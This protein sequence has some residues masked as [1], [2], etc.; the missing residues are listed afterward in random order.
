MKFDEALEIIQWT[1]SEG[2]NGTPETKLLPGLCERLMRAGIPLLRVNVYQ[3]T[4]H[5]MIGG[6][7][8]IWWRGDP[9]ARQ[10]DWD[11]NV[12]ELRS[13]E[14]LSPFEHMISTD[15]QKLRRRLDRYDET[16][17]FPLFDEFGQRGGTDYFA[18]Q[19][20]FG[21]TS[22]LG[23]VD[24]IL[25]SWLT[26][27]PDGFP[28]AHLTAIEQVVPSLAL[29]AKGSSTYR[30]ANTVIE[31]YLGRD[32]GQRVLSG[33]IERGSGETIR[34]T[35]W[36]CDLRGFTKLAD[37]IPRDRLLAML[38]DYF[39][40][41]V[42]TVQEFRGQVLKFMGDGLL[43][44]FT[45]DDD[46]ESCRAALNAAERALHRVEKLTAARKASGLPVSEFSIGLHLGEVMYGNIGARDR[47]DFTVVGP[48]VN[49]ASR[50]EAMCRGLEQNLVI[51]SAFAKAAKGSTDRLVS[52]GRYALR[53]VRKPQELFTLE[54]PE[55]VSA[56]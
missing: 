9:V 22:A 38:D 31:T 46:A 13:D 29:A 5:P 33:A 14:A 12:N 19:T 41:M 4:L 39:E 42:A 28:D 54:V 16:P 51:S 52:L 40:C 8:F 37:T 23:P 11:R 10:E 17:K 34:A 3:P 15:T 24:R 1:V 2:L 25:T 56:P 27:A 32:A 53:G 50:I 20:R 30:I 7:L 18:I 43:A 55:D 6:H 21:P 35:L 49:E 26:D 36:Y 48:A 47:L 44:I 45:L